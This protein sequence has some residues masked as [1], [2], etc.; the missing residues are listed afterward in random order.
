MIKMHKVGFVTSY[1]WEG[2]YVLN[3]LLKSHPPVEIHLILQSPWWEPKFNINNYS[4]RYWFKYGLDFF[5]NERKYY[6]INRV[7]KKHRVPITFIDNINESIET[8]RNL[9][10]DYIVVVGSR[11][12]K[13]NILSKY[14]NRIMNFHTGVLPYYRGPYS[15]FWAMF[16]NEYDKVGTTIHMLDKGIDTGNIIAQKVIDV[17]KE[18]TPETAHFN[19]VKHGALLLCEIIN[20]LDG[21][22]IKG[23]KQN[24]DDAVYY[25]YPTDEQLE[26]L[27]NRI[28]KRFTIQFIE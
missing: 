13:E 19:N 25:T 5:K 23:S 9:N 20:N 15:E 24:E 2:A 17:T 28:G 21:M 27:K 10:L 11:I 22:D 8:L 16:N 12:I 6:F 7:A 4:L 3:T 14:N 1:F 26:Y 18:D